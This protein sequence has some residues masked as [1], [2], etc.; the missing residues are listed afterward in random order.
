MNLSGKTI[1]ITGASSGIGYARAERLSKEDCK[2][3]VI[4]R[5]ID[6]L[7]AFKAKFKRPANEI[8]PLYCDVTNKENVYSVT[9]TILNRFGEIDIAILNAGT[10]SR[11]DVKDFSSSVGEEI[12]SVNLISNFYF[13]EKLIPHFIN[14]KSGMIVGVSSL[15]DVRGF[16]RSAFYNASKAGATR[17]YESLR[18]ELKPYGIKV[19]TVRPGFVKTP[20]TD[21]NEFY[22]PFMINADKAAGI[23]L[24]GIIKEKRKIQFP[25]P[26]VIGTKILS[27]IPDA[28]FESFAGK[29]L[30]GLQKKKL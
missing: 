3:A 1:L 30:E 10:S 5:R 12:M 11:L 2:L 6:K 13:L 29:H 16:P 20:M 18:I 26:T 28:W 9:E 21:K 25:L 22:M 15:A 24:R 7:E 8:I 4:A 27:I 14:K 17:L 19:I 23:I